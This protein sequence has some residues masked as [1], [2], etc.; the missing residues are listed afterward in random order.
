MLTGAV[1]R[2]ALLFAF[3]SAIEAS[4]MRPQQAPLVRVERYRS[5]AEKQNNGGL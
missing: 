5:E 1:G 3:R 2:F 4:P